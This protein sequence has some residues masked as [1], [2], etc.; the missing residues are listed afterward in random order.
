MTDNERENRVRELEDGIDGICEAIKAVMQFQENDCACSEVLEPLLQR[1]RDLTRIPEPQDRHV[2]GAA[3]YIGPTHGQAIAERDAL[4]EFDRLLH[5]A[6]YQLTLNACPRCY[7][8]MVR[9]T[10]KVTAVIGDS[11][12]TAEYGFRLRCA[13]GCAWLPASAAAVI[14][15]QQPRMPPV[16]DDD[17]D[18]V[19]QPPARQ[20]FPPTKFTAPRMPPGEFQAAMNAKLTELQSARCPQCGGGMRVGELLGDPEIIGNFVFRLRCAAGCGGG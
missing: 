19:P 15:Q 4:R 6:Q 16:A 9:D 20:V 18:L 12:G 3:V 10:V 13:A 14:R 7:G 1:L 2:I 17:V 11:T 5:V 8:A